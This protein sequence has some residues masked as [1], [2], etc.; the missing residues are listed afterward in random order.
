MEL[1]RLFCWSKVKSIEELY[2]MVYMLGFVVDIDEKRKTCE[3]VPV[4]VQIWFS[5]QV[6]DLF[7]SI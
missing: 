2:D 3:L 5:A 7:F 4:P 6:G 1:L